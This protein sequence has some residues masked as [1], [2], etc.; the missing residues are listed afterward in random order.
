MLYRLF[1]EDSPAYRHN[2]IAIVSRWFD[3]FTL[4]P[5]VGHYKGQPE[6]SV[7]VEIAVSDR[8][9]RNPDRIIQDIAAEIC[10]RN[11]QECVLVQRIA[12]AATMITAQHGVTAEKVAAP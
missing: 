11:D 1:T 12:T 7:I 8:E 5:C 3:G 2:V 4:I 10:R 6:N 9:S